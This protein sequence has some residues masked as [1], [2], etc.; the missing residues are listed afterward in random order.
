MLMDYVTSVERLRFPLKWK[1]HQLKEKLVNYICGDQPMENTQSA[2]PINCI[3]VNCYS[4]SD[5]D[6]YGRPARWPFFSEE[7][8]HR[9]FDNLERTRDIRSGY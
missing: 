3:C 4:S 9:H 7:E 6:V 2:H 8:E 5:E 1:L